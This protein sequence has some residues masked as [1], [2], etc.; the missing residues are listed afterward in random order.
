[1]GDVIDD[2]CDREQQD[3]D[4]SIAV[5]RLQAVPVAVHFTH[6]QFCGD[7]TED[8]KKFCSYGPESCATESGWYQRTLQRTG[9][10]R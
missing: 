3:R 1:M 9:V 2:G 6:C 8:G 4:L 10:A 5:A 7:P